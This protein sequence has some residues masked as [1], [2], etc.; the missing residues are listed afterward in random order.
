MILEIGM[1]VN[2]VPLFKDY[3]TYGFSLIEF[4]LVLALI[5]LISAVCIFHF[6]AIQSLFSGESMR[7]IDVLKRIISHG[8]LWSSQNSCVAYIE[9]KEKTFI[10]KDELGEELHISEF[11]KD[12]D[13][14]TCKFLAGE[15]TVEGV[16]RPSQQ[17]VTEFKI[18][19]SGNIA[20]TFVEFTL[21][22]DKEKYEIDVFSGKCIETSW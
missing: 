11:A 15:L 13:D 4:L 18:Y 14:W 6:D 12:G 9:C 19:P 21:A 2:K 22:D 8:R 3:K 1:K 10:L 5:G 17:T 20:S 16:L 7:P